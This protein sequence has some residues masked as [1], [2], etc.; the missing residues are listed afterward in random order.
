MLEATGAV[1]VLFSLSWRLGP[2]LAGEAPTRAV[3]HT[4]LLAT[5]HYIVHCTIK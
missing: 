2:V 4:I 1:I 3:Q 5:S